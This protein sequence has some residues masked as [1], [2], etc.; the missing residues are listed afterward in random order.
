[1]NDS[2][3]LIRRV[4]LVEA[5][6]YEAYHSKWVTDEHIGKALAERVN[7]LSAASKEAGGDGR[8]IV[9]A[10]SMGGLA[11]REALNRAKPVYVKPE[12]IGLAIMI[13]TPHKGAPIAKW[14]NPTGCGW[15]QPAVAAMRPGSRQLRELP[16]LPPT[17]AQRAIAGRIIGSGGFG[18]DDGV[19]SVYSATRERTTVYAGDGLFETRCYQLWPWQK[20][21]C[22][23]EN[24]LKDAAVQAN[25][26]AAL[27]EYVRSLPNPDPSPSPTPTCASTANPSPTSS[28]GETG[29]TIV[30]AGGE[31]SATPAEPSPTVAPSEPACV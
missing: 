13:G 20:P 12:N 22:H 6:N 30:G 5:F 16:V 3:K 2:I 27:S 18:F 28:G 9:V 4:N 10:H 8:V 14:C 24:L 23:H 21:S 19:V 1:M 26:M 11:L 29:G 31:P 25:V 7:C 15:V 17:V